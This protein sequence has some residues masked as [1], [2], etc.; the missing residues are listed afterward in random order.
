MVI[1]F[2]Q[3]QEEGSNFNHNAE[4]IDFELLQQNWERSSNPFHFNDFLDIVEEVKS[5]KSKN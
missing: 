4:M 2:T 5:R 1:F 3:T